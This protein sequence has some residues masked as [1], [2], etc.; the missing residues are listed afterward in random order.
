MDQ[1]EGECSYYYS[2]NYVGTYRISRSDVILESSTFSFV[3]GDGSVSEL[4][5]TIVGSLDVGETRLI[6]TQCIHLYGRFGCPS[7]TLAATDDIKLEVTLHKKDHSE[8]FR[9]FKARAE[10]RKLAVCNLTPEAYDTRA[11]T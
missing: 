7:L 6:A 9:N 2:E 8:I 5:D 3:L 11:Q 4:L 10:E 1:V